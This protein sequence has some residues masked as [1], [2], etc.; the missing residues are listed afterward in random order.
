MSAE[1]E[2]YREQPIPAFRKLVGAITDA[3][4]DFI[5]Y[6]FRL[7]HHPASG[8][9]DI[10]LQC[11]VK[12]P[13]ASRK[14][15]LEASGRSVLFIRD[16]LERGQGSLDTSVLPKFWQPSNA[17]LQHMLIEIKNTE[18]AAGIVITKRGLALRVWSDKI[19]AARMTLLAGDP[20]ITKKN[21]MLFPNTPLKLQDGLLEQ[22][23]PMSSKQ[24]CN[25]PRLP[26]FR[27]APF[28]LLVW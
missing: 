6:G 21:K 10:Q 14:P 22:L 16:Y 17:E 4:S 28:V 24:Q 5:Y 20:R 23:L 12:I 19:G 1:F 9:D 26:L 7:N 25:Q 11:I 2:K 15:L 18:G 27:C 13:Q 8:K 3:V